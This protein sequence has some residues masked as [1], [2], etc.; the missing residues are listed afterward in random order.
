MLLFQKKKLFAMK[1]IGH[2]NTY[3]RVFLGTICP[4]AR[5]SEHSEIIVCSQGQVT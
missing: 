2:D 5:W 3:C 4:L 1:M